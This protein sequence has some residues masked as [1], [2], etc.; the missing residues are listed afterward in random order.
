MRLSSIA[1]IK[2]AKPGGLGRSW[3]KTLRSGT[4]RNDTSGSMCVHARQAR[5][6]NPLQVSF[7]ESTSYR[8]WEKHLV[9]EAVRKHIPEFQYGLTGMPTVANRAVDILVKMF[10]LAE[11]WGW[12]RSMRLR[13]SVCLY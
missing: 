7:A 12:R 4:W 3:L 11:D 5:H 1:R 13:R 8:H 9:T 10:G 2:V 6:R